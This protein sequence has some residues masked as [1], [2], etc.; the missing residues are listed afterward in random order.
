MSPVEL[1]LVSYLF[2]MIRDNMRERGTWSDKVHRAIVHQMSFEF[3]TQLQDFYVGERHACEAEWI[4]GLQRRGCKDE[5]CLM[6]SRIGMAGERLQQHT[7]DLEANFWILRAHR[8]T[9]PDI[10][11]MTKEAIERRTRGEGF[12][13]VY[14]EDKRL[15]ARGPG[16]DHGAAELEIEDYEHPCP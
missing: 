2:R 10:P 3:G 9:H 6:E 12:P 16:W 4:G 11:G 13:G 7:E 1:K 5:T 8:Y 14:P 15:F